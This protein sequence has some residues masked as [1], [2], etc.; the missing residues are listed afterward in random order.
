M[1]TLLRL[2]IMVICIGTAVFSYARAENQESR[3]LSPLQAQELDAQLSAAFFDLGFDAL[4][5]NYYTFEQFKN[6]VAVLNTLNKM[7]PHAI[8]AS[9]QFNRERVAILVNT[10]A[11]RWQLDKQLVLNNGHRIELSLLLALLRDQIK[12]KQGWTLFSNKNEYALRQII[13]AQARGR[14]LFASYCVKLLQASPE[15]KEGQ[16]DLVEL[17][18]AFGNALEEHKTVFDLSLE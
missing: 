11:K 9:L 18:I 7:N 17:C 1:A 4:E 6:A 8:T 3:L 2:P 10:V 16:E 5:L 14:E 12:Q 13:E 15:E